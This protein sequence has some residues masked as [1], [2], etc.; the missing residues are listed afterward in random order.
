MATLLLRPLTVILFL[1]L[2]AHVWGSNICT[3]RGVTTCQQCLAVHP[4]C[5]WCSQKD[6]GKGSTASRCD[7]KE[8]LVDGGCTKSSLEFPSSTL[9]IQEDTALSSKASGTGDV[10][11][12]RPQKLHMALRPGDSKHF[13]VSVKQVEDYPVDLYYLMDLSFSMKDDLAR[14]R[15]LGNELAETMGRTTSNLR[16]GFGAF[17]DKTMGPY[18]YTYPPEAVTNPCNGISETCLAQF[19]FK[20]VLTLTEKVA[21]FT[22]EVEKQQVSRNRDAPEGGFDAVMQ[23]VVCKDK[24]GWRSDASHLLVFTTDAK[25]HIALDGRIAGIVQP[26]DGLCHLDDDNIYNKTNVLDYPSLALMTDKM[27][28]NNINLVFAVTD[29]VEPLY[30]EYSRLMPGTTVGTL[31]GDSGNVIQLIE[32]AYAKIRSK[33]ELELLEVPEELHLSFDATCLNG[34]IIPGLQ[35]CSGL[36]IGDTV[37]FSVEAELRG[38]PKEKSSTF[39]IKPRGFKDALVVTADFACNCECEAKAEADSPVCS[40]GN[41]TYECGVCQCHKGRLGP[42]C[43]CS[44]EDYNPSDDANCIPNPDS[45]VCSG[46]GDCLC[47]QCSCRANDFGQVWG[48]YCECDDY[49][50]LRFKGALCSDHGKCSCGFCQC[51]AGWKGENCNCSTRIDTCMSSIGLLCSGRGNCECGICQC[52]QPGAYGA[53]CE[54]CPTC[55]DSCTIKKECVECQHFKRGQYTSDNSCNRICKDEIKVVEDLGG[56]LVS[57][58]SSTNAVNCSYKDEVDC[59]VHFQY[60]EDE[61]GKS[62]LFVVKEPEC[63]EGANILVVLLSVAGAILL[64]GLAALLIWKLLITIHDR[65]EFARFEEERSK[66]KWDTANNPLYKGATSTF[67][68]VAYRGN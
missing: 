47:G 6:F 37:S 19:G 63:P 5:A 56:E 30:K 35:S 16:M 53:T 40:N 55:P 38:C 8:N 36:S 61:T 22:E 58:T 13:T 48:K 57:Q 43:E 1:S 3:S 9:T 12:I 64:L 15:T 31:S 4:T 50:C 33:V 20:H 11:Q 68:N 29:I 67:T 21:R 17:V 41:G 54:K 34:E 49:N 26:H 60:Y 39:T 27:S 2:A 66:A 45:P 42:H 7:L 28:E 14:L 46:R 32:E 10:T 44:V 52:T 24:I 23:A 51:D 18:M 65:R 25:T 59:V 62:I